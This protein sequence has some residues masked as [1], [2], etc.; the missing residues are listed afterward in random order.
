VDC[1]LNGHDAIERIKSGEPVYNAVFMDHMMPVMD[2]IETTKWIRAIG[3]EYTGTVPVIALTANAVAGNER[4]F[5]DEGFQAFV[6][7]PINVAKL[8][9]V[10]KQWIMKDGKSHETMQNP[11]SGDQPGN[12]DTG[13]VNAE[14]PEIPGI[15]TAHGIGMTGG[16]TKDYIKILKVFNKD[17]R[18]KIDSLKSCLATGDLPLYTTYIHALKS[19]LGSIGAF[20]LSD[21]AAIL[22]SAGIRG[23]TET[24]RSCSGVFFT[25]LEM[26]LNHISEALKIYGS[27]TGYIID[28]ELIKPVFIKMR[29]ALNNYDIA[30]INE[31]AVILQEY[32]PDGE[33]GDEIRAVLRSVLTG[34]YEEAA[35]LIG[36][37]L[38]QDQ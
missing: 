10:I 22:E 21:T 20:D 32:T 38:E 8:D 33:A 27:N 26:L 6:S 24:I 7:K 31:T 25:D 18:T 29:S 16:E 28:N 9:A 5:I 14:L 3:S 37:L 2:G 13:T 15:N 19:T 23:D 30:D 17:T 1:V 12:E 4:I 34:E 35:G 36:R 11:V